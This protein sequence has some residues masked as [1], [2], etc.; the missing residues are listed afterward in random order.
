MSHGKIGRTRHRD[1]AFS[2]SQDTLTVCT[3]CLWSSLGETGL[4]HLSAL[5]ALGLVSQ[6]LALTAGV[7]RPTTPEKC[8]GTHV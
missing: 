6:I 5:G 8:I 1:I 7:A 4:L 2:C 3:P